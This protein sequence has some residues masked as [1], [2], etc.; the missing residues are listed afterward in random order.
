M[1]YNKGAEVLNAKIYLQQLKKLD[2]AINQKIWEYD[3]LTIDLKKSS[4]SASSYNELLHK[5][6]LLEDEINSEIDHLIQKKHIIINQIQGL[7]NPFHTQVLFK[8]YVEYKS[9]RI[10]MLELHYGRTHVCRLITSALKEFEQKFL[11]DGTKWDF[12]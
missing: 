6:N 8:K 10:I 3:K 2:I 11:K 5:K 1:G 7:E 12:F 4:L 9:V